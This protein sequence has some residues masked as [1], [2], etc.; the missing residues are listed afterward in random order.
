M[1]KLRL[2]DLGFPRPWWSLQPCL[3]IS[4]EQADCPPHS[5]LSS[6]CC[7]K[8]QTLLQRTCHGVSCCGRWCQAARSILGK[9]WTLESEALRRD[10]GTW[11]LACTCVCTCVCL[12]V[13]VT[14]EGQGPRAGNFTCL[15]NNILRIDCHWSAP[16]LG[17][18]SSPWLLFTS[19]QAPGGTHKCILQGSECTV[20]LPP[21]AVLVPSD[22]FT[23]TFH[24]CVSGRE[25]VS[26]V[27]PE[28]LPRRH[29]KLDPPSD[30]QSNI[31]SGHCILTWS[32]SPALEPMTTLLNYELAFK[33]QEEAWERAQHRDHIVGVT[34]LVLEAFELDPGFILE[35]RLR[36]RMATLEDDVA[37][38]ERYTGQ[39]S[40]W[41]QPV[42]FQ[43]PQRQGPLIPPWGQPDN[44]LVAVSVF[45]L[46]IGLTYLL[47]KLSPRV[48]RIFYQNVPS[49]AAFF[50]PLYSVHNGNFQV[51]AETMAGRG[52][53]GLPRAL[54]CPGCWLS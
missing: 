16:E 29:V 19:N 24:H 11:L 18:G 33:K 20:V 7:K 54:A 28:Y 26:L 43:A 52:G 13:C 30:L 4:Q 46:L 47:F 23:I 14:E 1:R 51:C 53:Q 37:E 49:P 34:W 15:T 45:L 38:E 35:A 32:I 8:G 10:M 39:W 44:T 21:E 9:G 2:G 12:G 48:K 27:D 31:S 25:Q 40:E 42:Y 17:Q 36:V 5:H 6:N 3:H 41:S 50:R 22:N